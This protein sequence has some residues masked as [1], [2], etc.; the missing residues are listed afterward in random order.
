MAADEIEKN[1]PGIE[2]DD[3][4]DDDDDGAG[5][6]EKPAAVAVK[7]APAA[8]PGAAKDAPAAAAPKAEDAL[9]KLPKLTG[10]DQ[11]RAQYLQDT[12]KNLVPVFMEPKLTEEQKKLK[13][14]EQSTLVRN[15]MKEMRE[16]LQ[17]EREA[18]V[19]G[20]ASQEMY[21]QYVAWLQKAVPE[22]IRELDSLGLALP[23]GSPIP[24]DS[25]R[26][27]RMIDPQLY[28]AL[29]ADERLGLNL[30]LEPGKLPSDAQLDKLD[31]VYAW[32][33]KSNE[34]AAEYRGKQRDTMLN[35]LMDDNGLPQGWRKQPGEN[36]STWRN[37]AE[38]MVDL[39]IRTRNYVEAMQSLFKAS[40]NADFP[41]ELPRGTKLTIEDSSG[42]QHVIDANQLVDGATRSLLKNGT[43]KEVKLDLPQD[44]RQEDPAN[45]E[46]IARLRDWLTAHGE[47]IDQAV[48]QLKKVQD[49]PDSVIMFGDQEVANG[50]ALFNAKGEFVQLV[51][52]KYTPKAGEKVEDMNLIG[53]DFQVEQIKDGP[54]KGKYKITQ[55]IQ[56]EK[57]PWY[58]YQNI[59]AFGIEKIGQP[60]KVD[61]K[62][63][64]ADD[65]VPVRNGS[66][67]E[68]VKAKNL[69]SFKTMQQ[70]W[71]YGEKA[72]SITMDA[73]MLV[74]GT[75]EVGAAIKGARLAAVGAEAALKLGFREAAWEIGKGALRVGVAG[76]GIFNNAG[77]RS[78]EWGRTINTARGIY[79][80]ADIGLGLASTGWNLFRA[81]KVTEAMSS[82]D[83]VHTIIRGREAIDGAKAIEGIPWV[84]GIHKGT[85]WAFKAT[86]FGF[87][88]VIIADLKHQITDL[89]N[90][91]Q[92]DA[93]RDAILQVGDGRGL[94]KAE[95]GA[96][97]ANDPKALKAARDVIDGYT[98]TLLRGRSEATAAEVKAILDKTKELMGADAKET[99]KVKFRQELL[100]KMSFSGEQIKELELAH[101]KASDEDGFRLTNEDIHNLM[102]PEKRKG[103]PKKVAELAEKYI[104]E[105]D[106][107]VL[108][109]AQVSM[110]YLS[111]DKDG[112]INSELAKFELEVPEY[113]KQVWRPSSGGEDPGHFETVTV[114][115]RPA[116]QSLSTGEAVRNLQRDLE[117]P[118]LGNRGIVTG[119]VLVRLGGLTHQQYGGVLQDVLK[120]PKAS[121][122]DKLRA[123]ADS[124]G[125]RM[126]AVIDGVRYQE[127]AKPDDT[128][129]LAQ[130][131]AAG[132]AH[133]LTSEAMMAELEKTAKNEKE[134]ADVRAMAASLLYGL[135]EKDPKR[136]AE[137]LSGFN[138]M[139]DQNRNNEGAFA[140][141]AAEFLKNELKAETP[142]EPAN[143]ADRARECKLNAALS[144]A[145]ITKKDDAF[146]Q[147][148]LTQTIVMQFS[149][150]NL[151]LSS[152]VLDALMPE[153]FE[154]M[155]K[156]DPRLA[157][158]L[159]VAALAMLKKPETMA[160]EAELIKFIPKVESLLKNAD[161]EL[162]RQ[163]QNKLQDFIRNSELNPNYARFFPGLRAASI[164]TLANLGGRESLEIIR[165]HVSAQPSIKVGGKDVICGEDDAG[166]RMAS[167][168]AL[169]KL[170]DPL[171]R[172]VINELVDRETDPTVA[173]QLRDV[174]FTQQ[175]IEP[176]SREWKDLYEK[177][178]TDL[179]GFGKKYPY[180]DNFTHEQA[181][182]WMRDNFPLL[183]H[184]TYMERTKSAVDN[185]TDWWF[186]RTSF[187]A[188][189]NFEEWK[190][191]RDKNSDRWGQWR[192]LVDMAQQGGE[193]GN[194]AKM[195]LYY[196]ATQS[197]SLMGANSGLEASAIKG[198]YNENHYHKIYEHDWKWMA[199]R[200]IKHLAEGNCEG[201]DVVAKMI[202]DGLTANKELRASE[203]SFL[204]EGWR[205]L[206]KADKNG[207]AIPREELAR[208]TAEALKLET[209]R[210]PGAQADYYQKDLIADLKK[211]GHRM[212][213]PVMQAMV[214]EP[215]HVKEDVRKQA[216]EMID[217]FLHSTE[218]MYNDT[219][220]DQTST[221]IQRAER[222]KKALEDKNNAETTVQEIFNAYKDYKI[223]DADD[224]G[225]SQLQLAMNDTNE[226][227]R[228]AAAK[229]LMNSELPN[230]HPV[231]MKAIA[232]LV[233]VTLTGSNIAYHREAFNMLSGLKLEEGKALQIKAGN[234]F[235]KIEQAG[236]KIRASEF[237]QSGTEQPQLSGQVYPNGDSFRWQKNPKGEI[238]A[239]WDNGT[240]WQRQSADGKFSSEWINTST[241]GKWNGEYT[242][243]DN[244]QYKY[245]ATA[246]DKVHTRKADGSWESISVKK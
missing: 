69:E 31:A 181:K 27:G 60:M 120:D 115:A 237:T 108:A 78:T 236:G 53:Y 14:D 207:F 99:D 75:I 217:S 111:R 88:P 5:E 38:E 9:D 239:V 105:K 235:Y 233:D 138:T 246:G 135:R 205:A 17:K 186:R 46:K 101:P 162:K 16:A 179:I 175:R 136:R 144:L 178:R 43:I 117:D 228:L 32:L 37:S 98:D 62:I 139:L 214:D 202:K 58:A 29:A 118:K 132:K 203:S 163:F 87:A 166:V 36:D 180:L 90:H 66:K 72:L 130:E 40:R 7:D 177:T 21:K 1:R 102:D 245:L 219:K 153:R 199:A 124:T 13:P 107:D 114:K 197:G 20:P 73:A 23:P 26:Q 211:Y 143:I 215:G 28:K 226:R 225:L 54:D 127:S 172:S 59:R 238:V 24:L 110:L 204:L 128:S 210:L 227:V 41:I 71:Y 169:E 95:K 182:A 52:G 67:I 193:Q 125:P 206:G 160:Q 113:N 243:L 208:V 241:R 157:N 161:I 195:A 33:G 140:A 191:V 229:I 19:F 149:P 148:E 146:A 174:K 230:T 51:S 77:A 25:D 141:K 10:D 70:T 55:T 200:E 189:I 156:D 183:D 142:I 150:T 34:V 86:E 30:N 224:P 154:Q 91:G 18:G 234:R 103:Y 65:F 192:Q 165:S 56:A 212:V 145:A 80:L 79:F 147:K 116:E 185:A 97:D 44:L 188:T 8:A 209:R 170:A 137:L 167:V 35:K 84:K 89:A 11:K 231:K 4:W 198:Y 196:I 123:L 2:D 45:R 134:D 119:E 49:N 213:L 6:K 122:E 232:T 176:D 222:L 187:E 109:A 82:A 42:K 201:K 158:D 104:A 194:K 81:G 220:V 76:A 244:G 3:D 50:K 151:A 190:A 64:S 133:G 173:S 83:K 92:R 126:A 155:L 242:L 12:L 61:E 218:M 85:E 112:K 39:A 184:E 96:F 94:Q 48:S 22:T 223:K 131:R 57:A 93:A 240:Q 159:R 152:K 74:S 216:Q 164:D 68:L 129:R 63:I 171:L 168:R 221:K 47:K 15:Q 100:A 106:K 121:R